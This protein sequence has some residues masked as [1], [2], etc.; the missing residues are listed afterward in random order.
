MTFSVLM[1]AVG[2]YAAV[3]LA[4]TLVLEKVR[5][6][7]PQSPPLHTGGHARLHAWPRDAA[8]R[9]PVAHE[10]A[11]PLRSA[12]LATPPRRRR[13]APTSCRR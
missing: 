3:L 5:G 2:G 4:A 8:R 10:D 11:L 1:Y 12:Q 13:P 9:R 6:P 7:V